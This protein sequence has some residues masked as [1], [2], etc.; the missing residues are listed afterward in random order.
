MRVFHSTARDPGAKTV[1]R[2]AAGPFEDRANAVDRA[3]KRKAAG[4]DGVWSRQAEV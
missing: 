4:F 2:V 1:C 3:E